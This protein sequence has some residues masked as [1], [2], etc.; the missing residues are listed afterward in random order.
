[1]GPG[2]EE[3]ELL[4]NFFGLIN[5]LLDY[6]VVHYYDSY[7]K[8]KRLVTVIFPIIEINKSSPILSSA[9]STVRRMT[10]ATSKDKASFISRFSK[11]L[12]RLLCAGKKNRKKQSFGDDDEKEESNEIGKQ[13][14]L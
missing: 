6:G 9:V 12:K 1:M 4:L 14:L 2:Q 5:K 11:I 8:L 3:D 13:Y 10:R 7:P